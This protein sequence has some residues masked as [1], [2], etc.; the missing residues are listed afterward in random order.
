MLVLSG[1]GSVVELSFVLTYS[2]DEEPVTH[3]GKE[4]LPEQSP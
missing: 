4:V 2:V 3:I 1:P